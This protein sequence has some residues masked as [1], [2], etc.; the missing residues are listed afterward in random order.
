MA[1]FHRPSYVAL[2]DI[3]G[4]ASIVEKQNIAEVKDDLEFLERLCQE[5]AAVRGLQFSDTVLLYTEGTEP[6][7][8]Y[9]LLEHSCK[10]VATCSDNR[11]LLRGGI[12]CGEFYHS[13]SVFLG[14]AMIRAYAL[15]QSQDWM[16]AILDPEIA[17][18]MNADYTE[19][20]KQIQHDR[21]LVKYEAP[22]KGGPAGDQWCLGW[23]RHGN[24]PPTAP[25]NI[26]DWGVIRKYA[27]TQA[28]SRAWE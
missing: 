21:L 28:F 3:L 5:N 15:E 4:F 24:R 17:R 20:W 12:S 27:N 23:P 9:A 11:I 22:L 10:I 6:H 25:T 16:G 8:L 13:N 7:H 26:R 19:T 2:F 14:K 18:K 1:D